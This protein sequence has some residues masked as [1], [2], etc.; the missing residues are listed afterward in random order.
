M[1]TY[2]VTTER[3]GKLLYAANSIRE[4]RAW[5][6]SA[7]GVGPR[8]VSA[9]RTYRHCERCNCAPCCCEAES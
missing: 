3:F 8:S 5:A 9:H 6:K 1:S 4:A 7:F 2:E